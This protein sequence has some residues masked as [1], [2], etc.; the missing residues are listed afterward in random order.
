[1]TAR[2]KYLIKVP[3][4]H[5]QVKITTVTNQNWELPNHHGNLVASNNQYLAY[6]LE[7]RSGY[8]LRVIQ[9]D[10]NN[11]ALLKGFVGAIQDVAFAHA[12]SNLL[13][14]TDQGGNLHVWDL[15]KANDFS[16]IQ[17]YPFP[18]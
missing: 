9:Q 4:T 10:T 17:S 7:G 14:C 13:A 1:M 3:P 18:D 2:L 5:V 8:V 11:R 6:I 16:K 12:N 15:D